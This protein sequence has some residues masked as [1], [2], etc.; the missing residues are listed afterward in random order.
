MKFHLI[1]ERTLLF[2]NPDCPIIPRAMILSMDSRSAGNIM[3]SRK[4]SRSLSEYIPLVASDLGLFPSR[5]GKTGGKVST[6][7]GVNRYHESPR[8]YIAGA[9]ELQVTCIPCRIRMWVCDV[10]NCVSL[11]RI[12]DNILE[13][14]R[15]LSQRAH[16]LLYV[17]L[18]R[19]IKPYIQAL[20]VR[21]KRKHPVNERRELGHFLIFSIW[22]YT[23]VEVHFGKLA[24]LGAYMFFHVHKFRIHV[25][26]NV[27][28]FW[29]IYFAENFIILLGVISKINNFESVRFVLET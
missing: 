3:W 16:I 21:S 19:P 2:T 7:R 22:D 9:S 28:I 13:L 14:R 26:K 1:R 25:G 20:A 11:S 12:I 29:F 17:L 6:G 18:L 23:V 27:E 5:F 8:R 4:V 24:Y 15:V 10:R